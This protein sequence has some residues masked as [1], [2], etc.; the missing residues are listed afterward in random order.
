MPF[1][2]WPV[3]D[4]RTLRLGYYVTRM[5]TKELRFAVDEKGHKAL[6]AT[7]IGQPMSYWDRDNHLHPGKVTAAE[8][9]RG[10]YGK[11]SIEVTIEEDALPEPASPAPSS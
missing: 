1:P 10:T 11:P 3:K 6:A 2:D 5:V 7:L 9:I 8:V 4:A